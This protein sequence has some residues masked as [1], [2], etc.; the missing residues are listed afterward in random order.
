MIYLTKLVNDIQRENLTLKLFSE[1]LQ[2][3]MAALHKFLILFLKYLVYLKDTISN[4]IL[5]EP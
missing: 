2:Q 3:N 4:K 5:A 1:N